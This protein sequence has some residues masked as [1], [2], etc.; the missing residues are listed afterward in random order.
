MWKGDGLPTLEPTA[1]LV[2]CNLTVGS[3]FSD[4]IKSARHPRKRKGTFSETSVGSHSGQLIQLPWKPT[5]ANCF[6]FRK[7]AT[8]NN[9]H[10]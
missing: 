3:P 4:Y 6:S 5:L 1:P 7:I 8:N 9:K 2:A 10:K